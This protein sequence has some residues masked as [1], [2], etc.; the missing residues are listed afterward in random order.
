[1]LHNN[2]KLDKKNRNNFILIFSAP[3]EAPAELRC[4]TLTSE[5]VH[6]TWQPP[7]IHSMNGILR[8][9]KLLF[10]S[11]NYWYVKSVVAFKRIAVIEYQKFTLTSR[12]KEI[13]I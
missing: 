12:L 6:V 9:Y 4:T 7:S 10:S 3:G 2:F 13:I 1:M 5:S 8:G 11:T